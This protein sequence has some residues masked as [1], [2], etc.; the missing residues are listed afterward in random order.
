MKPIFFILFR[1]KP[2][3]VRKLKKNPGLW[4]QTYKFVASE[5]FW[6]PYIFLTQKYIPPPYLRPERDAWRPPGPSNSHQSDV[7]SWQSSSR[8]TKA[9]ADPSYPAQKPYNHGW[10]PCGIFYRS[11]RWRGNEWWEIHPC[12]TSFSWLWEERVAGELFV[13]GCF[14]RLLGRFTGR[15]FFFQLGANRFRLVGRE[16]LIFL[17]GNWV[18]GWFCEQKT[19]LFDGFWCFL[20][21]IWWR[22]RGE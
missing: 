1:Q 3:C 6:R 4:K 9:G 8:A 15:D 18:G 5:C 7:S 2:G 12:S 17:G 16:L 19:S 21:G 13:C 20:D 10:F 11:P 22:L 14:G